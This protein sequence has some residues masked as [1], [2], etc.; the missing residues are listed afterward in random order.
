MGS[1]PEA[2]NKQ[3]LIINIGKLCTLVND[4]YFCS[5]AF[6]CILCSLPPLLLLPWVSLFSDKLCVYTRVP[7]PPPLS[8]PCAQG[9][10]SG[11]WER[12]RCRRKRRIGT[13]ELVY[14]VL[15]LLSRSAWFNL[16]SIMSSISLLQAYKI[17]EIS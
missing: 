5:F 8:C 13:P 11:L 9:V 17:I 12:D 3:H 7:L 14:G 4:Y 2:N 1:K 10:E 15:V 16:S 6:V